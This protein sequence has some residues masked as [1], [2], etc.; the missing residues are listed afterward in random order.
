MV[1]YFVQ[2]ITYILVQRVILFT[3]KEKVSLAHYKQSIDTEIIV[4]LPPLL[5]KKIITFMLQYLYSHQIEPVSGYIDITGIKRNQ[6][7]LP[8]K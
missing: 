8:L 2:K 4:M 3:R 7:I 5:L 1:I 6:A